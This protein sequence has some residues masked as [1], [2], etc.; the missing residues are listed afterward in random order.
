MVVYNLEESE[1][2]GGR[3]MNLLVTVKFEHVE[4]KKYEHTKPSLG[5]CRPS[6][7]GTQREWR[8]VDAMPVSQARA[9]Q[10]VCEC[11]KQKS[12]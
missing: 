5:P 12:K 9:N 1:I 6:I 8:F 3:G 2:A 7:S 10:T 4:G 11:T